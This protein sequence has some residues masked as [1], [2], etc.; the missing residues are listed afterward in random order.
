MILLRELGKRDLLGGQEQGYIIQSGAAALFATT[1]DGL[2][3]CIGLYFQ[4]DEVAMPRNCWLEGLIQT[5]LAQIDISID[6]LM[7]QFREVCDKSMEQRSLPMEDIIYRL[8]SRLSENNIGGV[9]I[10]D[11]ARFAG[12]SREQTGKRI[13]AL[14]DKGLITNAGG[15]CW[16][17]TGLRPEPRKSIRNTLN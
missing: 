11:L 9:K 15:S 2:T 1:D 17:T 4:D 12:C 14:I 16:Q 8:L 7:R 13:N 6:V 5:R 10:I 3:G